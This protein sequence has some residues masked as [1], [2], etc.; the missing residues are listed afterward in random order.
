MTH[1]RILATPAPAPALIRSNRLSR[2]LMLS[3]HIILTEAVRVI[4][5]PTTKK[6]SGHALTR[7][8]HASMTG[9]IIVHPEYLARN[10]DTQ[11]IVLSRI[12]RMPLSD[13]IITD[14]RPS[15]HLVPQEETANQRVDFKLRPRTARHRLP[16]SMVRISLFSYAGC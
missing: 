4:G 6:T 1:H 5:L 7:S 10:V 13:L 15:L 2:I 3:K 12:K 14:R 16:A 9:L 8:T 11:T